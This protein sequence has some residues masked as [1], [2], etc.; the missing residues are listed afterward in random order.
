MIA[1][2]TCY[3]KCRSDSHFT[4]A[5]DDQFKKG[6]SLL[7]LALF[8]VNIDYL[9]FS[10]FTRSINSSN[11]RLR[12]IGIEKINWKPSGSRTVTSRTFH[13]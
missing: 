5:S 10:F 7:S 3:H 12:L 1:S 13:G 11:E 4:F 9:L 8:I 2:T 6:Q